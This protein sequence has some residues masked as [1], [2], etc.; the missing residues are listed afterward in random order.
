M[1]DSDIPQ[2]NWW[3]GVEG[4]VFAEHFGYRASEL[5]KDVR[6]PRN[7]YPNR[8]RGSHVRGEF[9]YTDYASMPFSEVSERGGDGNMWYE[10]ISG[11]V[12]IGCANPELIERYC[13]A[14]LSHETIHGEIHKALDEE[15]TEKF[16]YM[17][18]GFMDIPP[19]GSETKRF[20]ECRFSYPDWQSL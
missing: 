3:K 8:G 12:G 19:K 14:V 15:W 17:K 2:E 20:Y 13:E 9:I 16:D 6:E 4:R 18:P 10:P 1:L 11:T 7:P 5:I